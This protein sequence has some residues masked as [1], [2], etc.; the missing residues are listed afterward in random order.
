MRAGAEVALD[1][2]QDRPSLLALRTE[3]FLPVPDPRLRVLRGPPS[4]SW[5]SGWPFT[6]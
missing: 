2:E 5:R 1:N 4:S 6:P 3:P